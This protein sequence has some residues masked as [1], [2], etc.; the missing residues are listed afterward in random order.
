MMKNPRNSLA[1]LVTD[2][3]VEPTPYD[4]AR[5]VAA[6]P[7]TSALKHTVTGPGTLDEGRTNARITRII[8]TDRPPR[9]RF[10]VLT[11]NE[12]EDIPDPEWWVEDILPANSLA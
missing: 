7:T 5:P 10:K 8:G 6:I 1:V 2:A 11:F 12:V 9:P 3:A 4:A